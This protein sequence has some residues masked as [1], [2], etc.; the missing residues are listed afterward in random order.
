MT[1]LFLIA[2][3]GGVLALDATSVGQFMVSRPLV[4]GTLTGAL[5]GDP[6]TGLFIGVLLE[7]YL[8]VSF[9]SGGARFPEGPT[10]TVVAT[11]TTLA[12]GA[13]PA[14]IPLG[15]AVGLL[16]G[17]VGG[18][19]ISLMRRVNGRMIPDPQGVGPGRIV[20][21]HL[22]ALA[23]DFIRGTLVTLSGVVVGRAGG[24]RLAGG[25]PLSEGESTAL[26][27][28]G[29][30]VS[31]G[32]LLRSLGGFRRRRVLFVAGMAVGLIGARFI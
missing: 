3:M 32:I 21:A 12:V 31:A 22:S 10:A 14:A 24:G 2:V 27:I 29:G 7:L 13:G 16:W 9:P 15:I 17:Q 11:A 18:V 5:L 30:A 8:L 28:A 4:A 6:A 19:S 1:E 20:R 26:L 25:W 23:L